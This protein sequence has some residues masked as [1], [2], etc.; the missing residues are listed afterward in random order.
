MT[1][2]TLGSNYNT[3]KQV[4]TSEITKDIDHSQSLRITFASTVTLFCMW[5][6]LLHIIGIC[7]C[8]AGPQV[9]AEQCLH[10]MPSTT[11]ITE[12]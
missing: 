7:F 8:T 3:E 4:P 12:R 5:K 1:P 9:Q 11:I 10:M 6:Y 2:F